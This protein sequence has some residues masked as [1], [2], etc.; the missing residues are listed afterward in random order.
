MSDI[1]MRAVGGRY[2]GWNDEEHFKHP[3]LMRE[4][5]A[6]AIESGDIDPANLEV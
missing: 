6:E 3:D 5:L 1:D 4:L 2:L